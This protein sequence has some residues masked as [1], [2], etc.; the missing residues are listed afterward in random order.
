MSMPQASEPLLLRKEQGGGVKP[1]LKQMHLPG[2]T[3][4]P[5]PWKLTCNHHQGQSL[6]KTMV[7]KLC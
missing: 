4:A 1:S 6:K 5:E 2:D 3:K 7:P